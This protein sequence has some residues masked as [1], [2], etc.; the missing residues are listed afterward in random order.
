[1]DS[2]S[3][4]VIKTLVVAALVVGAVGFAAARLHQFRHAG[5]EGASA[6]FYDES[7]KK[8]YAAPR[9]TVP[10]DKGID[11]RTGDGV[12]AVVVR[13]GP[14][15]GE[16]ANRRIAYLETYTPELKQCLERVRAAK[17]AGQPAA[18][19]VP[20]RES[21]YFQTNELVKRVE[22]A[23]WYSVASLE[24]RKIMSEWRAWRGVGGETPV[25]CLP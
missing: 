16:P 19:R 11:R 10:P 21:A 15:A 23:E 17:A 3:R 14:K 25:V 22:D 8:L 18:G 4:S 13:L 9:D 7:A 12:R 2:R 1:M 20:E 5:E 6:W 24:G